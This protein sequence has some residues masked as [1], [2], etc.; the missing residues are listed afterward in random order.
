M[1]W[2]RL[3]AV[4]FALAALFV[5]S[6]A[7]GA[8][9]LPTFQLIAKDGRFYPETIEVPAGRRFRLEVINQNAGAE[10]FESRELHKEL[11][12]APGAARTLV[13][14]PLRAGAYRFFGEFHPKTARGQI[15]AR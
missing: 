12:L 10:E 13:F 4:E 11:V 15:V 7:A 5:S 14:A 2:F 8:E 3:L 9:N 6:L 1:C